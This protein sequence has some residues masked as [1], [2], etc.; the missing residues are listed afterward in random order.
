MK[1]FRKLIS[2]IKHIAAEPEKYISTKI[3]FMQI[4]HQ[5]EQNEKKMGF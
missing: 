2:K 4:F 1:L 3:D 5:L